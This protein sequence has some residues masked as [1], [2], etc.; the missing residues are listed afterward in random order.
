M[1]VWSGDQLTMIVTDTAT[2]G[3]FGCDGNI[4]GA[5]T[6]DRQGRFDSTGTY[7]REHGS[8]IRPGE[9]LDTGP[10]TYAASVSANAMTVMIRSKDTGD[11]IGTFTLALGPSSG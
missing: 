4:T 8:P 9:M 11:L 7:V 10:A 2:H 3:E 6:L 5:L 1:G